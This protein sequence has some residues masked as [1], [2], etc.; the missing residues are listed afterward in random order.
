MR[1][2]SV[3]RRKVLIDTGAFYAF[4]DGDDA[5]HPAAEAIFAGLR[6]H[7]DYLYTTSYVVAETHALLL[8]RLS[9]RAATQFLKDTETGTHLIVEWVTPTDV[10]RGRE[11]VYRYADKDFSLTDATSFVVMERLKLTAAFTFDRNFGQYGLTVLTPDL[12]R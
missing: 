10:T 6:D 1:S 4:A 7:G 9:H 5:N 11:I 8:N 2:R 12:V 3:S